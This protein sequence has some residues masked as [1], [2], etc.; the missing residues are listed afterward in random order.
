MTIKEVG[1]KYG[2]SGDTLRYYERVG[3]IP[4]VKRTAGGI[5]DYDETAV[6]WVELAVCMRN[7]GL[8]V[9]AIIEYVRLFETGDE[10]IPA[11]LELLR[12]QREHLYEKKRQIDETLARLDYKISRYEVAEKTG[13]LTFDKTNCENGVPTGTAERS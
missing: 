9:E 8:P 11:R 2:V 12:G 7:A 10:T 5:R 13:H 6:R 1:E 4:P 3:M